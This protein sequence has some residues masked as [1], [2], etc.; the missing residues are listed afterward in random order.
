MGPP[1]QGSPSCRGR[2]RGGTAP[3]EGAGAERG[4]GGERAEGAQAARATALARPARWQHNTAGSR[5]TALPAVATRLRCCT[6][7]RAAG[8]GA[9]APHQRRGR[10]D[11]GRVLPPAKGTRPSRQ[12]LIPGGLS[13][14]GRRRADRGASAAPGLNQAQER[15]GDQSAH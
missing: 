13:S 5:G 1:H 4:R 7:T 8:E 14:G 9:A 6:A 11:R 2:L 12:G 15:G 3:A 10:E